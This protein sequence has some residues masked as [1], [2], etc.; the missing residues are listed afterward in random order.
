MANAKLSPYNF[1]II[2]FFADASR[3]IQKINIFLDFEFLNQIL[4]CQFAHK[5]SQIILEMC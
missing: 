2:K 5:K 4:F 1:H 3:F